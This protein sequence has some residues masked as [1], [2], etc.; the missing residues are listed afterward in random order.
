[1]AAQASVKWDGLHELQA[2]L[3]NLPESLRDSATGIVVGAAERAY[4]DIH[5]AYPVWTGNLRNGLK[6]N[7]ID[8]SN[9]A[10]GQFSRGKHLGV[11]AVLYN[12]APH[13][14]IFEHGTETRSYQGAPRGS[15]PAGNIFIPRVIRH[16]REMYERL[17]GMMREYGLQVR[18]NAA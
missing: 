8:D 2:W 15:M 4:H 3:R 18:V 16:R 13:A 10:F 6:V 5:N 12:N 9:T 1:M 7:R 11:G 17:A 14:Y